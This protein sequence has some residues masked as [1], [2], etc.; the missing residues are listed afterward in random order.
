LSSFTIDKG[1]C[2][3]CNTIKLRQIDTHTL[4]YSNLYTKI[5]ILLT[6]LIYKGKLVLDERRRIRDDA[7]SPIFD[8]KWS[9]IVRFV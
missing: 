6:Y 2:Y 3:P 9:I 5:D 8:K 7:F 4:S 1:I